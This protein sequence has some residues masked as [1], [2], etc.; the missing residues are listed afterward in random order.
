[1]AVASALGWLLRAIKDEGAQH[2]RRGGGNGMGYYAAG[3]LVT[4]PAQPQGASSASFF[5]P[6][7]RRHALHDRPP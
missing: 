7:D 1:M 2:Q 3:S 4:T 5:V 6:S